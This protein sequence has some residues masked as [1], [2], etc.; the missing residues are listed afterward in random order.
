MQCFCSLPN[1]NKLAMSLS[2]IFFLCEGYSLSLIKQD[3]IFLGWS[4]YFDVFFPKTLPGFRFS[5]GI[6]MLHYF[7][8]MVKET[9]EQLSAYF[10]AGVFHRTF[11]SFGPSLDTILTAIMG[12]ILQ[13]ELP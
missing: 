11:S 4:Q 2:C 6:E 3:A 10:R 13:R 9:I 7:C 12:V 1:G 8:Y 5:L